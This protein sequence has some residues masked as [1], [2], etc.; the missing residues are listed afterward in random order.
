L[1]NT[2]QISSHSF[3]T[4]PSREDISC[5]AE[6]WNIPEEEPS[7]LIDG[8]QAVSDLPIVPVSAAR[9]PDHRILQIPIDK[10]G[11]VSRLDGRN[12][13]I[14]AA[15]NESPFEITDL[16]CQHYKSGD[17]Q[18]S[19]Q[20]AL[21][22]HFASILFAVHSSILIGILQGDL[23]KRYFRDQE[24]RS[25]L[26]FLGAES[27][28][29]R[30]R[31]GIYCNSFGTN[32]TGESLTV[33]HT[34][35]V[36]DSMK[37]YID[38]TDEMHNIR[39]DDTIPRSDSTNWRYIR[40]AERVAQI[41]RFIDALRSRI[42]DMTKQGLGLQ[43]RPPSSV[44]EFGFGFDIENPLSAHQKHAASSYI[45]DL[46]ASCCHMLFPGNYVL[47]Q[48]VVFLCFDPCQSAIA[49]MLFR[50]I[51]NDYVSEGG[52]FSCHPAGLESS[53]TYDLPQS[54]WLDFCGW[55]LEHTPWNENE[56]IYEDHV[57]STKVETRREVAR[58]EAEIREAEDLVRRMGLGG[59]AAFIDDLEKA[60]DVVIE[61]C[62][63]FNDSVLGKDNW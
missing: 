63:E 38:G 46:F 17:G 35:A 25:I 14:D 36:L 3:I 44:L 56:Q 53:G 6:A 18:G 22:G 1:S 33:E 2:D 32:D 49:E 50:L 27:A 61:A 57:A 51:G 42:R 55:T 11:I 4:C 62:T 23:A 19:A 13:W 24:T 31:P 5:A 10:E 9:R 21:A 15:R 52:D 47:H 8:P 59:V 28:A 41:Q 45:M 12:T 20:D 7:R 16:L 34:M 58:L 60:K 26:D 39:I 43:E 40:D 48:F 54:T 30:V 29:Q 37:L